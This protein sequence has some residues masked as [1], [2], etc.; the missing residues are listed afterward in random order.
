MSQ[1]ENQDKK[2]AVV[3]QLVKEH[4]EDVYKTYWS[5]QDPR[6][7]IIITKDKEGDLTAT[8]FPFKSNAFS[9]SLS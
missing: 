9:I 8:V 1:K 4:L 3:K 6:V 5:F 2:K 7:Q